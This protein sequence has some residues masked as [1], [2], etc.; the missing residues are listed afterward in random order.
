[1]FFATKPVHFNVC[2]S[3]SKWAEAIPIH[4]H[5]ASIVARAL[6][7]NVFSRFGAPRQLLSDRGR[8]FESEL[9]SE[10]MKWMEI[11]KLRTTAYQPSRMVQW[12]GFTAH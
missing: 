12:K 8:E 11:D 9:F 6:V 4:N 7:V 1:M 3:F 10:L 2:L 5:T